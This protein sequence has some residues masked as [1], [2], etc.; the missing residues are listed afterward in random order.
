MGLGLTQFDAV[1]LILLA[2]SAAMGFF[3]GA[4][5]E[6][7]S[8]IALVVAAG[9]AILG[10][11]TTAPMARKLIHLDWLATAAALIVVFV[12]VFALIRLI[13]AIIAR[14]VQQTDFL[15]ALDRSVGL[16]IGL[17]RGLIVLGALNLMF[18]AATPKDLQ[19]HWIVGSTTW[20]L[21][22]TMGKLLVAM[23]PRGMDIA[24]QL[25]PSLDRALHGA[26]HDAMDDRLKSEGYDARQRGEIEDL[27]E[28][29]R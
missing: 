5:L 16:L 9:A 18:N 3:R 23:A 13:G 27:V 11:S 17:A 29:S 8:L 4:M 1:V 10:L 7:V 19:P 20:P 28:K 14:Q 22:Q 12:I 15:G 25:K 26:A 21:S 2:I 24:G 6:I